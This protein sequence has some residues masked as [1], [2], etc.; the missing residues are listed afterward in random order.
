MKRCV[1]FVSMSECA[2]NPTRT[3]FGNEDLTKAEAVRGKMR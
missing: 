3:T 1:R 2:G